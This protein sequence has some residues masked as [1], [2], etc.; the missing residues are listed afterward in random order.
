MKTLRVWDWPVRV[1]HWTLVACFFGAWATGES[2][3]FRLWHLAFGYTAAV[4]VLFRIL[5][6]FVGTR[7]ARFSSFVSTPKE[8]RNHLMQLLSGSRH[9][10]LGHNPLGGWMMLALMAC[11]LLVVLSGY[12]LYRE[13]IDW[14][15]LHEGLANLCVTLVIF[16]LLAALVMSRIEKENLIKSM[17]TGYKSTTANSDAVRPHYVIALLLLCGVVYFFVRV[18]QGAFPILTQ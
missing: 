17:W 8:A 3:K 1:F 16:H 6:G 18:L 4:L 5:W 2:E 9:R 14:D 11:I 12:L 7:Y 10:H 15:D 13:L